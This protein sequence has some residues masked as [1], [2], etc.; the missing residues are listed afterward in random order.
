MMGEVLPYWA[1][2]GQAYGEHADKL[3]RNSL[4]VMT[5]DDEVIIF[6]VGVE[7]I[8]KAFTGRQKS[9]PHATTEVFLPKVQNLNLGN[10]MRSIETQKMGPLN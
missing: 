4:S 3:F 9:R 10:S 8:T 1:S 6:E 5:I 2:Q 7:F